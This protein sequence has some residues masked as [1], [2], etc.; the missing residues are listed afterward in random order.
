MKKKQN[1]NKK[2]AII[3][4]RKF[5]V[6]SKNIKSITT[7]IIKESYEEIFSKIKGTFLKYNI[8]NDILTH[9]KYTDD[10]NIHYIN[11]LDDFKTNLTK[12]KPDYKLKKELEIFSPDKFLF[13]A[14]YK[15]KL[16]RKITG[17]DITSKIENIDFKLN[18]PILISYNNR[19]FK[20]TG[21]NY[22]NQRECTW[23]CSNIR[24]IIK[25]FPKQKFCNGT[26]KGQRDDVEINKFKFYLKYD[27]AD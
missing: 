21:I 22:I 4:N 19:Y 24:K 6:E 10:T 9:I 7:D 5:N 15:I 18:T 23:K 12:N 8:N 25:N 20:I 13:M 11:K 26:I 17:K 3:K 2:K 14:K 16:K 1:K 27:H